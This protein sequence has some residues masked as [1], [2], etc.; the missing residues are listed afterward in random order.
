MTDSL[1][2]TAYLLGI[3]LI[4]VLLSRHDKEMAKINGRRVP[5]KKLLMLA[6]A[7]ASPGIFWARRLFR[8][9]TYK[10]P[11]STY[12][13]LIVAAQIIAALLIIQNPESPELASAIRQLFGKF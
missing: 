1:I 5:E 12:L 10:Q 8:H 4:A 13:K 7:G 9:K 2:I 11:F 6:L 3:N